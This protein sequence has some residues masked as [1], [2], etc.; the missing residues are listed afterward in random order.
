MNI[1][2]SIVLGIVQGLTEFLPISSSGHLIFFR[3]IL[4]W[5][6]SSDLSFDAI[7]QL[8]TGL[9]II[10]YFWKDIFRLINSFFKIIT[11]K[12]TEEKDKTIIFSII[13]GTIPA[14]IVGIFLE[15]YME[16]VFR[17]S[18]LVA[19]VLIIGSL[20]MY[21]AEKFSTKNKEL[22]VRKGFYI[23]LFQCLALVPGFSRSGA[24]ISGGLFLGLTREESARFSFLLSIP[25]ILGSGLKKT[26]EL[27]SSGQF[28]TEGIYILIAAITAFLVGLLA[29][30]FLINFLKK[31]SLKV[32]ICYRIV[33]AIL[34]I[35]LML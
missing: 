14:I 2:D 35:I 27:W 11:K 8:A 24:T 6:T 5:H 15:K 32:F 23:G 21:L 7:L 4:G 20:V 16:T 13:I 17:S 10:V 19:F 18:L 34:I 22:S 25:I 29:I 9:A 28:S 3:D 26:F 1:F 33:L 31:Y 30:K 12:E